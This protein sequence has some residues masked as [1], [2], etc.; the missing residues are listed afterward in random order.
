ME[1]PKYLL[2]KMPKRI[3]ESS[4]EAQA[5]WVA[6]VRRR[7][8]AYLRK[9][10]AENPEKVRAKRRRR[11]A[12]NPEKVTAKNREWR[13]QNPEKHW[14]ATCKWRAQNPEKVARTRVRLL[15]KRTGISD[16]PPELVELF[17]QLRLAKREL[18][19]GTKP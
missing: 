1:W 18:K 13:A 11:Y 17:T 7:D 16:P 12:K 8:A 9:Q 5:E 6:A 2:N 19:K 15:L 14:A 4:Y 10:Q 3:K